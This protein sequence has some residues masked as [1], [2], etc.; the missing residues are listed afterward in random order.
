MAGVFLGSVRISLG[1]F[2]LISIA[3]CSSGAPNGV[4]KPAPGAFSSFQKDC[5]DLRGDYLMRDKKGEKH[6]PP[7]HV[8]RDIYD[9]APRYHSVFSIDKIDTDSLVITTKG[10]KDDVQ[11]W[12][13]DWRAKEPYQY[14]LWSRSLKARSTSEGVL[15][16]KDGNRTKS[17]AGMETFRRQTVIPGQRYTCK[18][19]WVIFHGEE[20]PEQGS[21]HSGEVRLTKSAD[22]GLVGYSKYRFEQTFSLW[23]GDGCK[24]SIPLPDGHKEYWWHVGKAP[25]LPDFSVDWDEWI[26][27]DD[28]PPAVRDQYKDGKFMRYATQEDIDRRSRASSSEKEQKA[29]KTLVVDGSVGKTELGGKCASKTAFDD[30]TSRFAEDLLVT[31]QNNKCVVSGRAK[32]NAFVS[33]MLRALD[34]ANFGPLELESVEARDGFVL[35]RAFTGV[36]LT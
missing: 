9:R 30:I 12:F 27:N 28:R 26:Q 36:C 5:P 14:A 32:S 4:P 2:L 20:E 33:N 22:G 3:G 6:L 29:E 7:G 23:C 1:V 11:K 24:P 31:C 18:D 16:Y 34:E 10:T 35:F 13:L 15:L 19:G 21:L 8:L 25:F 17:P